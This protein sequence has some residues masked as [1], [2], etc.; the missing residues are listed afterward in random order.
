MLCFYSIMINYKLVGKNND[1][2]KPFLKTDLRH[3]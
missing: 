1:L 2:R 3:S